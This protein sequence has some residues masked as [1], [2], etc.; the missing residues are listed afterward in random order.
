MR[1]M[2]IDP[3]ISS[4]GLSFPGPTGSPVHLAVR[5]RSAGDLRLSEIGNAVSFYLKE[6]KID[7]AVVEDLAGHYPGNSARV[8]PMLH[9]VIRDRLQL[10]RVPFMLI[11]PK[12]LKSFATGN[13]NADKDEMEIAGRRHL[14][15][16]YSTDDECDADWLRV[17]GRLVYGLGEW[18]GY[19]ELLILPAEQ[20]KSLRVTKSG[21]KI[22]WPKI[23]IHL[24]WPKVTLR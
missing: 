19:D 5:P 3:S 1:I 22:E 7:F 2:G 10:A 8:I 16:M 6:Y 18:T 11:N 21:D 15:R 4:T 14:G 13:G 20:I 12:T 17:A 23:G 9:G 24:P